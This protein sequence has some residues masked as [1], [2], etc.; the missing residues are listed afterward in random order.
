M[1]MKDFNFDKNDK[2][3]SGFKIPDQYFQ[4]FETKMMQQIEAQQPID[5]QVKVVSLWHK[6]QVWFSAIAAII[7]L[8]IAI[9]SYLN[10]QNNT[11]LDGNTIENYLAQQNVGTSELTKHLSDE[12]IVALENS[13]TVSTSENDDI[14]SYLLKTENLDYILN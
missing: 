11:N 6:K 1:N 13:L 3:S 12:D 2:I 7:V 10:S 4:E 8:A 9:P 14:E 5:I